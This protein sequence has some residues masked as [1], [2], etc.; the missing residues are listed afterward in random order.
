MIYKDLEDCN[1]TTKLIQDYLK[2]ENNLKNLYYFFPTK[3]T[4]LE[5]A[6]IKTENY[7]HRTE[8]INY[9]NHQYDDFKLSEKQLIN[10]TKLKDRKT[11]TI[12]TGHQLMLLT[13]SVFFHYK[14]LHIIKL[15]DELNQEQDEFYFVPI[16]WL[17][18]EDHDFEEINHF[19]FQNKKYNWNDKYSTF[20]VG[21]IPIESLSLKTTLN[22]FIKDINYLPN[23]EK[24]IESIQLSYFSS[25]TLSEATQKLIH[26]WYSSHGL[27]W[28]DADNLQLKNL[29]NQYFQAEFE[30][31]CSFNKISETTKL[32]KKEYKIQVN[33]R[34]NN[35]F[36]L[37]QNERVRVGEKSLNW[38]N[39][40]PQTQ[41]NQLSPNAL[42]RPFY[43]EVILPNVAYIGGNA[44][45]AYWLELKNYFDYWKVPF[46]VLI[47][48][49]SFT[50]YSE[51]QKNKL[52]KLQI[53]FFELLND[54]KN[55]LSK[56]IINNSTININFN[57][58]ESQ[59]KKMYE[60]MILESQK[61]DITLKN[62]LLAQQKRQLKA[63]EVTKK[64]IL[65][66]EK[67]RQTELVEQ[68]N[69][70]HLS[71]FPFENLQERTVNFTEFYLQNPNFFELIY[72][73][74]D[75]LKPKFIME[76]L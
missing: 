66:A 22:E 53:D 35:L 65:K 58:L 31:N 57:Q 55:A 17:A 41:D 72:K 24:I 43:Q 33:P 56:L 69:L 5:Q 51:K 42:L 76:C 27:L 52:E 60:E 30:N 2:E 54:K 36:Y 46:P 4:L 40:F 32:L 16:F 15:C 9:L 49:N 14:I 61:T 13:G 20:P 11:V 28:I 63:F 48:R 25:S 47:P 6:K 18:S 34:E 7:T 38:K 45:I 21:R 3:G 23:A 67:R 75:T 73:N 26:Y 19:Y 12:T 64:R 74:T 59:V 68:F 29:M 44:E 1:S 50:F 39:L 10:F 37:N 8:L 70:L 62:L 71:L